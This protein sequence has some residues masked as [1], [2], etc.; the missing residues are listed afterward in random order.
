MHSEMTRVGQYD[1]VYETPARRWEDGLPIGNGRIGALA[2]APTHPEWVVNKHDVYDYRCPP[3]RHLKHAQVLRMLKA[4][5]TPHEI[6]RAE[7][8]R[9]G[10]MGKYPCP[11]TCG[12]IRIRFGQPV[13]Y[14][15]PH[16]IAQQLSLHDST[17]RFTLDKHLSHPRIESLVH[18]QQDVMLI[19]VRDVS[20][21]VAFNNCVDIWREPD[22]M[23]PP[24]VTFAEGNTLGLTQKFPDGF[25]FVMMAKVV[26]RGGK[27]YLDEFHRTIRKIWWHA[28]QPSLKVEA[29]IEGRYAVAPVAGDF[30]VFLTV[31]TSLEARNP[32]AAAR[33]RLQA[34]AARG[35]AALRRTHARWWVDFWSKSWVDLNDPFL[36]Q[37]WH[38]SLHAAGTTMRGVPAPGLCGL[39]YGPMDTPSQILPWLGVYTNDYNAQVPP[40]PMLRVNHPELAECYFRTLRAQLPRVKK[41][42]RALYGWDGAAYPLSTDPLGRPLNVGS[43]RY[44]HCSGPF[45]GVLLWWHYLYTRDRTFLAQVSYPILR[46]VATFFAGAMTLDKRD[47]RYHLQPSQPPEFDY[48]KYPDPTFTLAP[49]KYTLQAAVNASK[50]L[51]RDAGRR[52]RWEHLLRHF[53]DYPVEQGI[54][55]EARGMSRNHT[56]QHYGALMPAFPCGEAAPERDPELAR[57]ARRTLREMVRIHFWSYGTSRGVNMY[58]TGYLYKIGAAAQW[59]GMHAVARRIFRDILRCHVKPSG[60]IT[61]NFAVWAPSTKSEAN[62]KRIPDRSLMFTDGPIPYKEVG[63]G[64]LVED[65]TEEPGGKEYLFPAQEGPSAYL[66]YTG[67]M[68]LQ[69]H[70]GIVRVFPGL[71]PKASASFQRLRAEGPVLVSARAVQGAPRFV[72]LEGL[73]MTCVRI[74]NP[75]PGARVAVKGDKGRASSRRY[76]E[77]I[78]VEVRPGATIT[79][80]PGRAALREADRLSPGLYGEAQPRR[81]R[82]PDGSVTWLGKPAGD[83]YAGQRRRLKAEGRRSEGSRQEAEVRDP[84]SEGG[85]GETQD[86]FNRLPLTGYA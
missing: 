22:A 37:L 64:R 23:L 12:Q 36:N 46:E 55:T 17:A 47:G 7:S 16:R 31:V 51:G 49:L 20:R 6:A 21:M 67:E 2:Y 5:K 86:T 14:S 71:E 25:H 50:I 57:L 29:R 4:G 24:A 41:D 73:V 18:A 44:C 84:R 79:L 56:P 53:P 8:P 68:L 27:A 10:S 66:V 65:C 43:L 28:G 54:I 82:F 85:L 42:T 60:L 9:D 70:N 38:V 3:F 48:L 63:T 62:I 13:L 77:Y 45:W 83:P 78:D 75:W 19:R 1:V 81:L 33:R 11:K 61:H 59:L 39:W 80:A 69:S 35:Y 72:R 58:W 32:M 76:G 74:R 52:Q 15:P 34:A 40:T 30:D 26:P